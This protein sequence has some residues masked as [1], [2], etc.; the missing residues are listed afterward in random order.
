[1]RDDFLI[2]PLYGTWSYLEEASLFLRKQFLRRM[3]ADCYSG[4]S[5]AGKLRIKRI[6]LPVTKRKCFHE[7]Y[8]KLKPFCVRP[9][10]V[11]SARVVEVGTETPVGVVVAVCVSENDIRPDLRMRI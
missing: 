11:T 5:L 7:I 3:L 4:P 8:T 6:S 9:F 1:M 2:F 10:S